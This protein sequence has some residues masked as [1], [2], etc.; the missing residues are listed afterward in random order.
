MSLHNYPYNEQG[1]IILPCN[2]RLSQ[3]EIGHAWCTL[4]ISPN[5]FCSL[6]FVCTSPPTVPWGMSPPP[7]FLQTTVPLIMPLAEGLKDYLV[8][9]TL[10][11]FCAIGIAG[12]GLTGAVGSAP[13]GL[14]VWSRLECRSRGSRPLRA[15]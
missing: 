7:T 14:A 3:N 10:S 9:C 12:P 13:T 11:E 6:L 15:R 8:P 2:F 5:T 4:L 1:Q